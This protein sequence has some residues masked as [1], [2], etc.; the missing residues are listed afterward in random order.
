MP[1]IRVS[2]LLLCTIMSVG[3]HA[4]QKL[5]RSAVYRDNVARAA[6]APPIRY[7]PAEGEPNAW[8]ALPGTLKAWRAFKQHLEQAYGTRIGLVL[9]DHYQHIL[10]G[11]NEGHGHNIFWWNLSIEQALWQDAK[12]IFKA[13]G[14]N[15]DGDP[16]NGITQLVGSKL[17]L[18]WAA[19][20]TG[21]F[22]VANAYLE[23]RLLDRK[24]MMAV[25]KMT[26]P[27]Y[28]DEN[29]VAGWDFFSHS[30]ARNQLFIHRYHTI[31]ALARYDFTPWFYVQAGITDADGIRSET[32]LNTAFDGKDAFITMGEIGFK[33]KN[34]AG[35]EGNYRFDFWHDSRSFSRWDKTGSEDNIVGF[36]TSCDQILTDRIGIFWRYSRDDGDVRTFSQYWSTGGTWQGFL[37]GRANDVLGLGVGQG[38]SS[39]DYRT[40]NNATHTETIIEV[41]YKI[42]AAD[43]LSVT[44]DCQTLLNPGTRVSAETAVIPGIRVK[45]VF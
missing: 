32:G 42:Y 4:D 10:E 12:F 21:P 7:S 11:R 5:Q 28:F 3:V 26:C 15:T 36:G 40:A 29:K 43:F 2:L 44:L 23:Q 41:Y 27:S 19:Y 22:Y 16:P 14:S 6:G 38:L 33:W 37:P 34:G 35:R 20:E 39:H 13:R 31:S 30:M 9:D 24:L 17:N 25:G 8:P 1:K 45:G 18:D